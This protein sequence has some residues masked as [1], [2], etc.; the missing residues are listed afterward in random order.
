MFGYI[1]IKG[2]VGIFLIAINLFSP[3]H[4]H[5]MTRSKL[6]LICSYSILQNNDFV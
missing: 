5:D 1:S 2:R 4:K 3:Q 6:K